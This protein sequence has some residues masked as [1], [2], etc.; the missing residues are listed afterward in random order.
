[1]TGYGRGEVATT[2]WDIAAEFSGVNRKQ[3][4]LAINLPGRLAALEPEVRKQITERVS[5][6]RI[7]GRITVS[8]AGSDGGGKSEV[9]VDQVL[10][11]DYRS[12]LE[13]L[14]DSLGSFIKSPSID[15]ADLLRLPGVFKLEESSPEPDA[16][17]EPIAAAVAAGLEAL[18]AMQEVEGAHLR[19]DLDAR[20]TAIAD[21]KTEIA[22]ISPSVK[23]HYRANLIQRLRDAD[24]AET[25][26]LDL[27]DDRI[28]REIG[29]FAERCDISEELTRIDS[30][31]S[32]FRSYFAQ[33]GEGESVGR[34]LDFLC[35]ELHRELNTIGSKAN[36]ARIAQHIVNAKTEL[37]KIR[38]QVQN[39]Q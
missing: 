25:A 28:L 27:N 19:D 32:Q 23:E 29:L 5:R 20:I 24:I 34:P 3:L 12:K 7:N 33:A 21:E 1:M 8:P 13:A 38:E 16:L 39:V 31:V 26:Q 9:V 10:L 36:D 17:A 30:H 18:I 6:G 22:K 4:D 37:E 2:E 11:N 15:L 14:A 35:Q